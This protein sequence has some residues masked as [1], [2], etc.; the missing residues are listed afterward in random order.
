ML[1]R[2][3]VKHCLYGVDLDPWAVALAKASLWLDSAVP[4]EEVFRLDQHLRCGNALVGATLDEL[5]DGGGFDAVVGNPPYRGVRTGTIERALAD[6]VVARYAAAR[7]NWDL[8]ALFL[9]KS[10][11]VAKREAACGFILPGADQHQPR[12]L[13]GAGIDLCRRRPRHGVG[14]RG[15]LRGS[16][17]AGLDRHRGPPAVGTLGASGAAQTAIAE[18][19]GNSRGRC[20]SRCPTARC[21]ARSGAEEVPLFDK[22]GQAR[23]GWASWPPSFAAWNAAPMI[24]IS[25]AGGGPAGCRS[26]PAAP[27]TEFRI[28]SQGLFMPPGLP[29]AAKYKR[30]EL[31][32]TVPKLLVRFVARIRWRPWI[33]KAA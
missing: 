2:R 5:V 32:E 17:R 16:R 11:A 9:E 18:R 27:S 21:S 3:V 20:S 19:P 28:E 26:F 12:L 13:R 30:R 25:A 33:C 23:I 8:A 24:P 15:S 7:R 14:L 22:L 31:F 1:K 10:L 6:Y 4:G 29:P